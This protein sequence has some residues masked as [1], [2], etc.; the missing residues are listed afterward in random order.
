[1]SHPADDDQPLN[2]G[3]DLSIK[4]C[5]RNCLDGEC[6]DCDYH[7]QQPENSW[8][9]PASAPYQQPTARESLLSIA[10][11]GRGPSQPRP[12]AQQY[13]ENQ[14][15]HY[16]AA[17]YAGRG[18]PAIPGDHPASYA[19]HPWTYSDHHPANEGVYDTNYGSMFINPQYPPGFTTQASS[20]Q[21]VR[22]ITQFQESR[23]W[24]RDQTG[25]LFNA[26]GEHINE[27]GDVIQP[28]S[29]GVPQSSPTAGAVASHNSGPSG[30][31]SQA[32]SHQ[33]HHHGNKHK[34]Q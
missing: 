32:G 26:R 28:D 3:S 16:G 9:Q 24:F 31:G 21:E 8:V 25:Q 33:G 4:A 1:M 15:M 5:V 6:C 22:D 29:S 30:E 18:N 2:F 17:S 14:P 7:R 13:Q 20:Y 10:S 34:Y 11:S 23:G 12:I 19:G 27:W